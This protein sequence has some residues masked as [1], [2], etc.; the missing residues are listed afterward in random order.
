MQFEAGQ[1]WRYHARFEIPGSR[2]IIGALVEF[3][4]GKRIACCAVTG[5]MQRAA[6]GTV[7]HVTVPFVPMTVEA[8]AGTVSEAD[9]EGDLPEDFSVQFDA[10]RADPRGASYFTVP[11]EGSLE[12][13]IARQMEALVE[14]R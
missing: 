2:L 8:L 6:D 5:A 3:E 11:F 14:T 10:W 7:Q 1:R 4:G 13:M 9:G 12:L